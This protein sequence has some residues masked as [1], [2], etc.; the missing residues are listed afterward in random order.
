[1]SITFYDKQEAEEYKRTELEQGILVKITSF[2]GNVYKATIVKRTKIPIETFKTPTKKEIEA[3][4]EDRELIDSLKEFV[5]MLKREPGVRK[6]YITGS[7]LWKENPSDIDIQVYTKDAETHSNIIDKYETG[8]RIFHKG[9]VLSV[10]VFVYSP[11][12]G[13]GGYRPKQ[14]R[15]LAE[16]FKFSE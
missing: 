9:K 13:R 7:V 2:P 8:F 1:M 4:S 5:D 16:D 12:K 11:T 10:D 15:I 3:M 14:D 6:I